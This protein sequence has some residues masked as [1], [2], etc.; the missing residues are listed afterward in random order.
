MDNPTDTG[1]MKELWMRSCGWVLS[2]SFATR[3]VKISYLV[4]LREMNNRIYS[5]E[6]KGGL[7]LVDGG[8]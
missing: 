4:Y 6:G 1:H 3:L 2:G 8:K 7:L 5:P